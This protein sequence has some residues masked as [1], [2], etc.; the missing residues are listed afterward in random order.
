MLKLKKNPVLGVGSTKG[1]EG[2]RGRKRL[3]FY[4]VTADAGDAFPG[5]PTVVDVAF[6]L[7]THT[8]PLPSR[9]L[10]SSRESRR[11]FAALSLA[12]FSLSPPSLIPCPF[13]AIAAGRAVSRYVPS[14]PFSVN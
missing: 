3:L 8:H 7:H 1:G 12:L 10:L 5:S 13:V 6:A 11:A 4:A 9:R 14:A 2:R